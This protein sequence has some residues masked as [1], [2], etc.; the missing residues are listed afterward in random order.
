[1]YFVDIKVDIK[2][3]IALKSQIW[4]KQNRNYS[5]LCGKIPKYAFEF[6]LFMFINKKGNWK[7]EDVILWLL[8]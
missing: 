5:K 3:K 1:M 6:N 2:L 7:L 8:Y 4:Y